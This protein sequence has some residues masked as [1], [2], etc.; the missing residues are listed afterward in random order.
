ME[1]SEIIRNLCKEK[2]LS[3]TEL[4]GVLGFS[5]GSLTKKGS[6]LR[7]DRLLAVADFFHVSMEFLMDRSDPSN[8]FPIS[9]FE[10]ELVRAFR[11]S[12]HQAA[13]C[14]LLCISP[15]KRGLK[16]A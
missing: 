15:E 5:N 10:I 2:H 16:N 4:E 6:F 9:Q 1:T 14:D 13:I 3:V 7:S 11:Q 12:K 8:A